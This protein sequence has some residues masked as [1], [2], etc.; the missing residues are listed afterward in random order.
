M[1]R[2]GRRAFRVAGPTWS[3][4][5]IAEMRNQ[6]HSANPVGNQPVMLLV[7]DQVVA[8]H[9]NMVLRKPG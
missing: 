1:R 2:G 9:S 4:E 8:G 6:W 7:I 3:V 5:R